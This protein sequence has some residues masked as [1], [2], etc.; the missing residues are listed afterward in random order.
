MEVPILIN[1]WAIWPM[2]PVVIQRIAGLL[3]V[4]EQGREG[5]SNPSLG[6]I[7]HVHVIGSELVAEDVLLDALT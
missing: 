7:P 3:E 1:S 5:F 4:G 2:L 6:I